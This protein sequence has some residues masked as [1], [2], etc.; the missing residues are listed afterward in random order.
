MPTPYVPVDKSTDEEIAIVRQAA[1]FFANRGPDQLSDAQVE[2]L[3][4]LGAQWRLLV[5]AGR[6]AGDRL[7][8]A[9]VTM[10][11][12]LEAEGGIDAW[13]G[14]ESKTVLTELVFVLPAEDDRWDAV[15]SAL[16]VA[17]D[18]R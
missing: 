18:M 6:S 4:V 14:S 7:C 2:R 15:R 16:D 10:Y 13:G 3:R 8:D 17:T 5:P 9:Y 1:H 12:A 11:P